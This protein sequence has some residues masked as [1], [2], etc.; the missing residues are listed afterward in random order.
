MSK[1]EDNE[2]ALAAFAVSMQGPSVARLQVQR[3]LKRFKGCSVGCR[4][5]CLLEFATDLPV[6]G[7]RDEVFAEQFLHPRNVSVLLVQWQGDCSP[8]AAVPTGH[9]IGRDVNPTHLQ[10]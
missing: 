5:R 2:A 7:D 10:C 8:G 9:E 4:T 6:Q 1:N 3:Q